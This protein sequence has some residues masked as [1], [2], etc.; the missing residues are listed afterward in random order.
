MCA[1]ICKKLKIKYHLGQASN[2]PTTKSYLHPWSGKTEKPVEWV[3]RIHPTSIMDTRIFSTSKM[4]N[5][6][7]NQIRD[8]IHLPRIL[9]DFVVPAGIAPKVDVRRRNKIL[10]FYKTAER[11]V[12]SE[13]KSVTRERES[14]WCRLH[15]CKNS[16]HSY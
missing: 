12:K 9:P 4:D 3:A 5:K 11:C 16:A 8:L 14:L 10:K 13:N 1:K 7:S 2:N 6:K 15:T